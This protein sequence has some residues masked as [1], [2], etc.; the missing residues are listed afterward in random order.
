MPATANDSVI[1]RD[2]FGTEAMRAIFSDEARVQYYLDIEAALTRRS[3]EDQSCSAPGD[4]HCSAWS[5][6]KSSKVRAGRPVRSST[7]VVTSS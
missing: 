7:D 2:I 5:S 3:P 6:T 1:F 4:S